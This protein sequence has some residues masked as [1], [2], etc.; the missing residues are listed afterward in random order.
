MAH[1]HRGQ[2]AGVFLC[3][4]PVLGL[5]GLSQFL[6]NRDIKCTTAG[7]AFQQ[8]SKM[9]PINQDEGHSEGGYISRVLFVDS[10]LKAGLSSPKF[11]C[12]QA[13]FPYLRNNFGDETRVGVFDDLKRLDGVWHM[14]YFF[15]L[16]C[17]IFS[18][19]LHFP[20]TGDQ[21]LS[22]WDWPV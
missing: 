18:R 9:V 15:F 19:T 3:L 11:L 5:C 21:I 22:Q 14:I 16:C 1:W 20:S 2:K 13:S 6:A 8:R 12:Y 10:G 17:Q 4:L 7:A